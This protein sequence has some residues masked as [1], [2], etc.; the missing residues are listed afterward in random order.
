MP[1]TIAKEGRV[2]GFERL[3]DLV[4]ENWRHLAPGNPLAA[5]KAVLE[6]DRHALF[7]QVSEAKQQ[8]QFQLDAWQLYQRYLNGE[9][10]LKELE[11]LS[12]GYSAKNPKEPSNGG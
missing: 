3:R 7:S 8:G 6:I 12:S 4:L 9:I 10:T 5:L 11:D 1:E 2:K